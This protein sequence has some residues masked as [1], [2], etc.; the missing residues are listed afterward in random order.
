M[1]TYIIPGA[2]LQ[3]APRLVRT[4]PRPRGPLATAAV[5]VPT[6]AVFL[7]IM[8]VLCVAGLAITVAR[9]VVHHIG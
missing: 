2:P 7:A 8:V 4:P 5:T 9:H 3:F 6:L 1:T